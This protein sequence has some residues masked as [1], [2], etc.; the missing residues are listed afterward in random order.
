MVVQIAPAVR[1]SFG[2]LL[3]ENENEGTVGMIFDAL[4]RM[5]ADYVFD[6]AFSADI[7]IMEKA[8]EF[9]ER[10]ESKERIIHLRVFD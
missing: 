1:A 6:T 9:V 10:F 5:G 8:N 2:E 3:F 4:K 7:T